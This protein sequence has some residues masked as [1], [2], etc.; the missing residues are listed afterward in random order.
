VAS[1]LARLS[2]AHD[3]RRLAYECPRAPS[4]TA[5]NAIAVYDTATAKIATI[6]YGFAPSW[7]PSGEWIAYFSESGNKVMIV[8]PDGSNVKQVAVSSDLRLFPVWSPY[9][10][11]L[12]INQLA[13]ENGGVDIYIL[14][15]ATLKLSKR[16]QH[17]EPIAGWAKAN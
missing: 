16:F 14:D 10:T 6:A 7:S 17:K 12:L 3:G 1:P 9:S 15:L 13:D 11:H 4:P 5:R 8:R 2:W